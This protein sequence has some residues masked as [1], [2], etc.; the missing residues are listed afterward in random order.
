MAGKKEDIMARIQR[1]ILL[2]QE[3]KPADDTCNDA[4]LHLIQQAF[5]NS[6]F[7][8]GAVH[9]FFCE[10]SEE[11]SASCGFISGILSALMKKG[12][13]SLWISS[14]PNIFPPAFSSFDID[15]HKIIFI[16]LK[17]DKEKLWV[18]EEALKCD[19]LSCVVGELNEISF[20]ESRRFQ[21][22][23]EQSKATAFLLRRN[24]KNHATACVTRWQIKTLPGRSDELPG[25]GFPRWEVDLL[26]VRNGKPGSWQMEWREGNFH[27][28]HEP[29]IISTEGIRKIV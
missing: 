29:L 24:P 25:V 5:P 11:A 13:A 15:A 28:V 20:T 27:L 9:E 12:G 10:T 18:L 23:V 26:K 14:L 19:G 22:A 16:H 6:V 1:D 21:L 4:G 8:V 3:F 2:L 17:N 7:P